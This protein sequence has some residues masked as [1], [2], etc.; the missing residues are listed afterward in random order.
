MSDFTH[1]AVLVS[2]FTHGIVSVS[3]FAHGV[4]SPDAHTTEEAMQASRDPRT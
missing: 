2:D 1:G 3:D 4:V